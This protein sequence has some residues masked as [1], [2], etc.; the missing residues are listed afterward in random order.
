MATLVPMTQGHSP[1]EAERRL[2]AIG[3]PLEETEFGIEGV[4]EFVD[5]EVGGCIL[6]RPV[7]GGHQFKAGIRPGLPGWQRE[8]FAEWAA[9]RFTRFAEHGPGPDGWQEQD[10]DRG[11]WQLW[12]RLTAMPALD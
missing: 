9:Q 5:P 11:T 1:G 3:I 6:A 7:E 10:G 4:V 8:M 12:S 2:L